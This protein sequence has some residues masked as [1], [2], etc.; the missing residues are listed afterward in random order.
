MTE[1][2]KVTEVMPSLDALQFLRRHKFYKVFADLRATVAAFWA[3]WYLYCSATRDDG[4][5]RDSNEEPKTLK[6]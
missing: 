1:A 4:D 3:T 2:K 5:D 6:S